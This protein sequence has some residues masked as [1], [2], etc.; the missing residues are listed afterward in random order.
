MVESL[1][2]LYTPP[3][4]LL[5]TVNFKSHIVNLIHNCLNNCKVFIDSTFDLGENDSALGLINSDTVNLFQSN[6]LLGFK[7][8]NE[9]NYIYSNELQDILYPQISR[10][11]SNCLGCIFIVLFVTNRHFL[12]AAHLATCS[13][14]MQACL[15]Q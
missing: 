11:Y 6:L 3:F 15:Y 10:L 4:R 13:T 5:P 9:F 1:S 2:S 14:I 12:D 8:Q 7:R